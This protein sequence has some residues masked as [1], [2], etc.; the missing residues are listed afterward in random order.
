[1]RTLNL[2]GVDVGPEEG[3]VEGGPG[4]PKGFWERRE[5]I[6][7]NDRLLRLHGGSWRRPPRLAPGWEAS[8][9]LEPERERARALLDENF[10]GRG[11]WGWKDPRVSFTTAFWQRLVPDLRYVICLRNPIDAADSISPPAGRKRDEAFYYAR[12]GPKLQDAYRLWLAY[13][14][15]ALV[16][17]AGRRRAFVSYEDH[18]DDRRATVERLARFLDLEPPPAGGEV[19]RRIEGFVED[20]FRHYRTPPEEVVVDER[21]PEETISLYLLT[22]LLKEATAA[23]P[24]EGGD[25]SR[26]ALA[27]AVGDYARRLVPELFEDHPA[28]ARRR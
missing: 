14:A 25:R 13:V 16:N 27:A 19:E 7:L 18:F 8:P 10:A 24:A 4:A 26:E 22:E 20:R 9:E 1:M 12:R 3:L 6:K 15:G 11:L 28:A 17:T 2:L 21:L 5:I 23:P